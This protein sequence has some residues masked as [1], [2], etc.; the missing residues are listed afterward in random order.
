M[1]WN[2]SEAQQLK[3]KSEGIYRCCALTKRNVRCKNKVIGWV[4][5]PS[6]DEPNKMIDKFI[7][8]C[9]LHNNECVNIYKDYKKE[10]NKIYRSLENIP[11][12]DPNTIINNF[13]LC[14]YS[15]LDPKTLNNSLT[16]CILGRYNYETCVN[17]CLAVPDNID[18]YEISR[19]AFSSHDNINDNLIRNKLKCNN[20]YQHT[21][22]NKKR[23]VEARNMIHNKQSKKTKKLNK[24]IE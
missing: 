21:K 23:I 19:L 12:I 7:P 8:H 3:S 9:K 17:G 2:S 5:I 6:Y 20:K 1:W 13:Q 10:C 24:E 18:G 14:E 11:G 15:K 16:N 22:Q 4:K